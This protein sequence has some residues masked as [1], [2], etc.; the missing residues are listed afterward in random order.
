MLEGGKQGREVK[1]SVQH[2]GK[3]LEREVGDL[4]GCATG[5]PSHEPAFEAISWCPHGKK[6]GAYA[7]CQQ[8]RWALGFSRV[9]TAASCPGTVSNET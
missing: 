4:Q 9:V 3:T 2:R 1:R 5:Q 8:G 7:S 6:P